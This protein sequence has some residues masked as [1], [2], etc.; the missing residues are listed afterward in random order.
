MRSVCDDKMED[1]TSQS[2]RTDSTVSVSGKERLW[3]KHERFTRRPKRFLLACLLACC[4]VSPCRCVGHAAPFG[5]SR[6]IHAHAHESGTGS[7][8][9]QS[10]GP[11]IWRFIVIF[12]IF[13]LECGIGK[14]FFFAFCLLR[15]DRPMIPYDIPDLIIEVL[16]GTCSVLDKYTMCVRIHD[17]EAAN[18]RKPAS[19]LSWL[20]RTIRHPCSKTV[21]S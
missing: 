21:A 20:I 14:F 18:T 6:A 11:M 1:I 15:S 7:T 8:R 4:I 19:R 9:V 17:C 12:G 2:A 5:V 3:M 16:H 10:F 13:T